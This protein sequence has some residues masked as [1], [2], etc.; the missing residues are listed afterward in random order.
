MKADQRQTVQHK[1]EAGSREIAAFDTG[2]VAAFT[3]VRIAAPGI[4]TS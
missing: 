2:L 4:F 3:G 1:E